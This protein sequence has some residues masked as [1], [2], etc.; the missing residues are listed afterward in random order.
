MLLNETCVSL[1]HALSQAPA[2][3]GIAKVHLNPFPTQSRKEKG[4][5]RWDRWAMWK[6]QGRAAL[7]CCVRGSFVGR[8][9]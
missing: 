2:A 4:V 7:G 3:P 1:S 6:H 8:G 9:A 5:W